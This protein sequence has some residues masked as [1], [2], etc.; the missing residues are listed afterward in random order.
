MKKLTI[1]IPTYNRSQELNNQ[2]KALVK[3]NLSEVEEIIIIDNNSNYDILNLIKKFNNEKIKIIKNTINVTMSLNMV[4]PFLYCKTEWLWLISDD[5]EVTQNSIQNIIYE[6]KNSHDKTGLIKFSIENSNFIQKKYIAKNLKNLIDYYYNDTPIR[7]G[8]LVFISTNVYNIKNIHS[9]LPYAYEFSYTYIG[10][11][12]PIFK[13]LEK[14][15]IFVQFSNLK[16][17]KYMPPRKKPYSFGIVG[18]GLS[19]L[20]HIPLELNRKDRKKFLNITMSITHDKLILN[21]IQGKKIYDI[22]DLEIIYNNIY[23][24]Y[25]TYKD[26]IIVKT[27]IFL[28]KFSFFETLLKKLYKSWYKNKCE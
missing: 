7:R 18:K 19:T 2:L 3:Q 6:I 22:R 16:I 1:A 25:I 20:S 10:Y 12:I 13:A 24:Y 15:E 9:F 14:E 5:D 8:D 4:F 28:M 21:Y 27:F 11:L 26:K 23:K 17:V